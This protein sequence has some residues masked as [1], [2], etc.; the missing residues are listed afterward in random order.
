MQQFGTG[1]NTMERRAKLMV[2]GR[3][4][5]EFRLFGACPVKTR[6]FRNDGIPE[7]LEEM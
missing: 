2:D 1:K 7:N 4:E 3:Y 6:D 5:I